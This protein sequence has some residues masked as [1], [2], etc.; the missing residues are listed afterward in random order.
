MIVQV[1][2]KDM[3]L[4]ENVS[5]QV[6]AESMGLPAAGVAVAV[7]NCMVAREKW[8]GFALHTNDQ[9]VVIK[10]ACGG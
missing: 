2:N 7:N 4:P 8:Q 10:A 1:N 5:L 9:I 6:L 3:E